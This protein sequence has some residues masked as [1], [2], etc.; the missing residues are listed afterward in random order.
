M[1][2]KVTKR[3][4]VI[5]GLGPIATAYFYELVIQMTDARIDQ[6]HI[7][8]LIF[9]KPSIPDRTDYI[10][11]KSEENPVHD[12]IDIGNLLADMGAD[13]I[14]IPCIT[15]HYFHNKL[16]EGIGAPIIHVIRE[17]GQYLKDNKISRAGIMATEGTI[18]SGLFQEEFNTFGIQTIIPSSE[19]QKDITDLIYKNVKANL[20]VEIN[21][22]EAAASELRE[23]G[24]EVIIL[25]CTELSLIKRDYDIGPGFLDAM[26]VLAMRAILQCGAK[27]KDEYYSL[28]TK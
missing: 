11:G 26:E 1:G 6:E 23:G 22:F 18:F 27:L 7:E 8:M 15:A 12:M 5:G 16:A 17:T 3:L 2:D 10:L 28:I 13:Q 24:A 9:S 14:A 4:G 25:G 21:K 20:P 19:K